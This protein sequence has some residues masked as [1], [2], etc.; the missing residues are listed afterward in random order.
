MKI[1]KIIFSPTGGTE[2][3]ANICAEALAKETAP[4][5]ANVDALINTIDLT[6]RDADFAALGTAIATDDLCIIAVPSYGGRV[7]QTALDRLAL[8]DGN[9]A[10]AILV[11]VYGNREF[12]DTLLELEEAAIASN[13]TQI[14]GIAA[15]AEHSI[16]RQFAP[17]RPDT[18]DKA[19]LEDFIRQIAQKPEALGYTAPAD[20]EVDFIDINTLL[21]P[22]GYPFKEY[23][24]SSSKPIATDACIACG[25]CADKCPVAAIPASAPNTT[26]NAV[27]ISCM[28]CIAICPEK[29]R[30]LPAEN[31]A[32][33]SE[34]LAPLCAERKANKL[35]L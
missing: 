15:I 25:L 3:V 7:P 29:A 14:A 19:Q 34:R 5:F 9:C 35:Y 8:I 20:E 13:F 21:L 10:K 27:C 18:E 28:R 4:D 32:A 12:D 33:V 24:G 11:A 22:G 17:G 30:Q 6:D 31:L 16:A 2:K 23:K 26:D 1:F